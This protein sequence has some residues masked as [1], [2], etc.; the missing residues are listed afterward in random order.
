[1]SGAVKTRHGMR[2]NRFATR[3]KVDANQR[4]AVTQ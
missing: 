3:R 4:K 1:M 2:T